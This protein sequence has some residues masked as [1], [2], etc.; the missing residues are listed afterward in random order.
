MKTKMKHA[1]LPLMLLLVV[2]LFC[3]CGNKTKLDE[4]SDKGYTVSVKYE[5]NGGEFTTYVS[6]IV[7]SYNISNME[8]KDGKV[9]LALIAPENEIRGAND[10]FTAAKTGYFLAGWGQRVE[11][12]DDEG[13]VFYTYKMWDFAEDRLEVD[14]N[15]QYSASDYQLTLYAIWL[16]Q[17][18]INFYE[19]GTGEYLET[20]TYNPL[21]EKELLKL[22]AWRQ[23]KGTI[24][25]YDF[26]EKDDYTFAGAYLDQAC[27]IPVEVDENNNVKAGY[28][29]PE[30]G[31]AVNTSVNIYVDYIP[32]EWYHIYTADQLIKYA[33]PEG[34]YVIC[35]DLDFAGKQWPFAGLEFS[36]DMITENNQT[37]TI[38]NITMTQTSTGDTYYG[39]FGDVT[40]AAVLKNLAFKNVELTIQAGAAKGTHYY[41]LFAGNI[42]SEATIENVS[43]KQGQ[44]KIDAGCNLGND[45]WFGKVCGN[46]DSSKIES[47]MLA[48]IAPETLEIQEYS[49]GSF[50]VTRVAP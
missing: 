25:M 49:D 43:L 17:F 34:K 26:P 7:D 48:V 50:T 13:N 27:T 28:V 29:D 42:S 3:A 14:P 19:A 18:E 16:P 10:T 36:G 39:M 2:C 4:I 1:L 47:W 20:Y 11:H 45:L 30:T 6:T 32:G 9:E 15:G 35:A 41:G 21:I 31:E 8:A 33:D 24:N 37:F 46:G 44:I 40:E 5:A 12:L 23:D 22:P 38:S